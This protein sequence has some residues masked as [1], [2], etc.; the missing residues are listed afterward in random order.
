MADIGVSILCLAYNHEKYIEDA[1][2]SFLRQKT[3]FP[4]E[5][6]INEDCPTDKTAE[7]IKEYEKKTTI[8]I[9]F[10]G[11]IQ[12]QLYRSATNTY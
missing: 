10:S 1:I 5:I 4:I 7:I 8:S 11:N 9:C 6:I 12:F 3:T 2:D